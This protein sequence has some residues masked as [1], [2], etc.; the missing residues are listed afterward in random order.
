MKLK[1]ALSGVLAVS[2]VM[3][4]MSVTTGTM[5]VQASAKWA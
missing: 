2:M 4:G 1:K 5:M 3:S